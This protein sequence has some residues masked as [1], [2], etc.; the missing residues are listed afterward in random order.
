MTLP[1]LKS[2]LLALAL[3]GLVV[4]TGA[5]LV[6]G[7][8]DDVFVDNGVVIGP[9]DGPNGKYASLDGDGNL[10]VDL[11]DPGVNTDGRTVVEQVF[12]IENQGDSEADVWIT[13][14][15]E[16]AVT[17]Y[18]AVE[19]GVRDE[20]VIDGRSIQGSTNDVTLSPG[21]Q[22]VVSIEIDTRSDG[23][24]VGDTLL[25]E[26]VLHAR[27]PDAESTGGASGGS[28]G[29]TTQTTVGTTVIF[30]TDETVVSENGTETSD[31]AVSIEDL[32]PDS[33][34]EDPNAPSDPRPRA[35][36]TDERFDGRSSDTVSSFEG[37]SVGTVTTVGE[38]VT[39][40]G[41]FS[42]INRTSGVDSQRRIVK[43]VDITAP[44][45]RENDAATVRMEVSRDRLAASNTEPS[46]ARIGHLTANGWQLLPTTVVSADSETVVLEARTNGF[47]P[48]AAFS[49]S[50]VS[51]EW[52]LPNGT[53]VEG[54]NIRSR[55]DE[56][57]L[58]NVTLKITDALGQSDTTAYRIL[59]NDRPEI[60][61]DAPENV[62]A[63]E[64]TTLRA[65]VTDEIGNATVSWELPDG[66]QA[67]GRT[68]NYTF[69][70][71]SFDV[72]ATATDDYGANATAERTI[73]VGPEDSELPMAISA[74]GFPLLTLLVG[75]GVFILAPL[76]AA[77]LWRSGL[78]SRP[79]WLGLPIRTRET[80]LIT[81][82]EDPSWDAV[83]RRFEIGQLRVED[84]NGDLETVE[85]SVRSDQD[86]EIARKTVDFGG[87]DVYEG[88]P[89]FIPGVANV[90]IDPS[91]S[92]TVHVRAVDAADNVDTERSML[93]I[94]QTFER[95]P[96]RSTAA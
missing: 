31:D 36:I 84:P 69:E 1:S 41:Q 72:T 2:V 59:V 88:S 46:E 24:V 56:P 85:I 81:V 47:S 86:V 50:E 26:I 28:R 60:T 23:I 66:T 89:V 20:S 54:Q 45:G 91:R 95:R 90:D 16:T 44:P 53:T 4:P 52:T 6:D 18:E 51:Y 13:H 15:A 35:V 61:I 30:E 92:Y 65:N 34:P 11:T 76:L 83:R 25:S 87:T 62:T 57:G 19:S 3:V 73:A 82:F 68:V 12:V 17:L 58:Y 21:E 33:I 55:F 70:N 67:E 40:D 75:L 48:F 37:Q 14:D 10:T 63:N 39:L 8:T 79:G 71:G 80:P 5:A 77:R 43:A 22:L 32:D 49:A 27:L 78:P 9:Y 74:G 7:A 42:T 94:L 29:S 64:P 93:R 96:D 38:T